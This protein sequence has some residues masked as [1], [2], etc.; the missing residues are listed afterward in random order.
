MHF[1]LYI[2]VYVVRGF[3]NDYWMS[4]K[5]SYLRGV[6]LSYCELE[7]EYVMLLSIALLS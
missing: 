5:P 3:G 2:Y 7:P 1:D 4:V 6:V